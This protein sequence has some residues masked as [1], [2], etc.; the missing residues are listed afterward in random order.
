MHKAKALKVIV[1]GHEVSVFNI[2]QAQALPI[3]FEDDQRA[4]LQD[5][6]PSKVLLMYRTVGQHRFPK[7]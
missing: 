2:A 1:P 7:P 4:T 5:K 3:T 6:V